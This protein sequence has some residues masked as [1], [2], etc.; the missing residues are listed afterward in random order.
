[1]DGRNCLTTVTQEGDNKI[2]INQKATKE[3]QKDVKSVREYDQD[4][5]KQTITV[6]DVVGI[7][8]WKRD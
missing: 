1:M 3:G 6:D 5:L 4:G 7:Q 8:Y 2:V